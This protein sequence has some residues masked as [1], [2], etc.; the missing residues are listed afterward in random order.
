[1]NKRLIV[2]TFL[3]LIVIPLTIY[4]SWKFADRKYYMIS[5]L[6]IIYTMIPFFMIFEGRKPQARELVIIAVLCVIAVI[7]RTAF[8]WIP[9]FKPMTGIIIIS[10][11]ALGAEAGFLIGAISGFISNFIF[12][13][14]PWTPWQMFAFGIAGFLAGIFYH[15]NILKKDKLYLSIF[16]GLIV[17]II[18]GPILDTSTLFTM[19]SEVNKGSIGLVYLSGLPVNL[20]HAFAT[21]LTLLFLS[22][23]MFEKLERIKEKYGILED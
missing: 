13:Q 21:A 2:A 18:V 11:V 3:I 17:L 15:K 9:H 10:G 6:I 19:A 8:I 20:V 7:S 14:G 23:P 5:L 1:M 22:E 12:G 4:L 16:G